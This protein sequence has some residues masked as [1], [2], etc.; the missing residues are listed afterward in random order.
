VDTSVAERAASPAFL[1]ND[2]VIYRHGDR[3]YSGTVIRTLTPF[4]HL[5]N[6]TAL[7]SDHPTILVRLDCG[8][9]LVV[10]FDELDHVSL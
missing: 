1:A 4:E 10:S 3:R 7:L 6:F 5:W 8:P 2:R 9:E